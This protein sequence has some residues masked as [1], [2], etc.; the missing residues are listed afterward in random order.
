TKKD[1]YEY[2]PSIDQWTR[3]ADFPGLAR[4][5]A[6]GFSVNSK[7]YLGGGLTSINAFKD[8]YEYDP[9]ID[10]WSR[11]LDFPG[12]IANFF[13]GI[14]FAAQGK[15]Y[16]GADVFNALDLWAL[17]FTRQASYLPTS[18]A[19][20][21]VPSNSVV[22]D[23][24]NDTKIQVET[25]TDEDVIRFNVAGTQAMLID[26]FGRVGIGVFRPS[27]A[28][29]VSGQINASS[30]SGDGSLLT[31]VS[32]GNYTLAQALN[33]ANNDIN[34]AD[35]VRAIAFVGDGGGL[36]NVGDNLGNH[37]ATTNL[38]LAGNW[39]SG[40]GDNQGIFVDTTGK[41]GMGTSALNSALEVN[42]NI[43][44]ASADVPL[45][46]YTEILG[47]NL[48]SP[49]LNLSVNSFFPNLLTDSIGGIFRIDSRSGTNTPL[50]Q[51]LAKPRSQ[52]APSFDDILMSLNEDGHL[53]IGTATPT[54]GWVE[55]VGSVSSDIGSYGFFSS[56][57]STGTR[58][59]AGNYSIY[60]NERIATSELNVHSDER[61]KQIIGYSDGQA[62]LQTL[63]DI[64]ITDYRHIDTIQQGSGSRKK[65]IAQQVAEV[66]PQAV[67]KNIREVVPDI[68]QRATHRDGWIWLATEL[69]VGDRVKLITENSSDLYSVAEVAPHRFRVA[70][71]PL[72]PS[73]ATTVFVYG[74][75]VEDFH[76]VDYEAIS[77]LN[78][79]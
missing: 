29:D 27:S 65:V 43:A 55:I 3:K 68:Y 15:G 44:I 7:G 54:R 64:Q 53:G 8:F 71:L 66:F 17:D 5:R 23:T 73:G 14:G 50:F 69:A 22:F 21:A 11:I 26:S 36:T 2:D 1:F 25:R 33:L 47:G 38:Q 34:N 77:M 9:I 61:I 42:G 13:N 12:G 49:V 76:T 60:A 63:M 67:T 79:S 58:T 20:G 31:N 48:K 32:L 70:D 74:R 30:F 35:T 56:N 10:A 16:V 6:V 62:D 28:L 51:W 46:L 72:S 4:Q 59:T 24:D 75:E 18:P 19:N 39:L 45:G 40:D 37:T 57:T 78:V 41:V 52:G